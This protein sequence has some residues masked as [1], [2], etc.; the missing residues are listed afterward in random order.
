MVSLDTRKAGRGLHIL[1]YLHVNQA[2][3]SLGDAVATVFGA[4]SHVLYFAAP[5]LVLHLRLELQGHHR[6]H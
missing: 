4:L 6:P 2:S 1:H 5:R 3:L